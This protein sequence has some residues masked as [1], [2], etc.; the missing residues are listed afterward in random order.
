[1]SSRW[2]QL[3]SSNRWAG[4]YGNQAGK[5]V[6]ASWE[7]QSQ[8]K[9]EGR[10]RHREGKRNTKRTAA[11]TV[12]TSTLWFCLVT[13]H[14]KHLSWPRSQSQVVLLG[15]FINFG[16][17]QLP[18]EEGMTTLVWT[19]NCSGCFMMLKVA[20]RL[21]F[22]TVIDWLIRQTHTTDGFLFM[23][24]LVNKIIWILRMQRAVCFSLSQS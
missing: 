13:L 8:E 12:T 5:S 15:T 18:L 7:W 2:R 19:A 10:D 3:G 14:G 17:L 11:G 21:P 6:W 4:G 22:S 20:L 1:M 9:S 16:Q 24:I 23:Q